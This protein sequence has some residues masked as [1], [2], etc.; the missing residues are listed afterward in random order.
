LAGEIR[1]LDPRELV[2]DRKVHKLIQRG[3]LLGL[4]AAGRALDASGLLAYRDTAGSRGGG[5][6]Q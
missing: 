3:D 6:G 2:E 5:G 4:Y 1:D